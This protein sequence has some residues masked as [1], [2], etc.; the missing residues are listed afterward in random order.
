MPRRSGILSAT[1]DGEVVIQVV[2]T[3]PTG[4]QPVTPRPKPASGPGSRSR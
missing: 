4:T 3:G 1:H 2:G